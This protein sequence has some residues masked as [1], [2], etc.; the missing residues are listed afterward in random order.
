MSLSFHPLAERE[1]NDA[2]SYYEAEGAGLGAAFLGEVER[3]IAAIAQFPDSGTQM[4]EVVRRKL[5]R[6]F[7]YGVLYSVD[8]E[9]LRILAIMN[10]HRRPFY[11]RGRS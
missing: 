11:W 5:V 9:E 3:A 1:L 2:A 7:P 10:L 8:A 4:S 6:R